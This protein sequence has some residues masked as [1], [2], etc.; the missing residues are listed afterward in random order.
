MYFQRIRCN[1]IP[2]RRALAEAALGAAPIVAYDVDWQVEVVATDI[3][4]EWVSYG[5]WQALSSFTIRML[6]DR[7]NAE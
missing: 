2:H 1:I 7:G 4:G 6:S 5:D 3:T